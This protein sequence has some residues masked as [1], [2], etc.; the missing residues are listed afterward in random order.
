MFNSLQPHAETKA[1]QLSAWKSLV[2]DYFRATKQATVDIREI[3]AS[4]LF[5]NAAIKSIVF[6]FISKVKQEN[7]AHID[8]VV[9]K[10]KP[11]KT[12]LL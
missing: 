2:L 12:F 6:F 9:K 5:N 1:K 10:S 4:P 8:N 3:H 11:E 7:M